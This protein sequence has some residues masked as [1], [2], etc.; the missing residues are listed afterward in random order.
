MVLV[1][2]ARLKKNYVETVIDNKAFR[3]VCFKIVIAVRYRILERNY[4]TVFIV[5]LTIWQSIWIPEITYMYMYVSNSYL[6]VNV[7]IGHIFLLNTYE[8]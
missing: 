5:T 4:T 6:R 2:N 3:R 7:D 8:S 1:F